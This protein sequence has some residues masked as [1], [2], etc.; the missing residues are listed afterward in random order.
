VRRRDL[1][2]RVA[3]G[4]DG[5]SPVAG[6]Y[7]HRRARGRGSRRLRAAD[8]LL[9]RQRPRP[10]QGAVRIG[11][12]RNE[13][14]DRGAERHREGGAVPGDRRSVGTRKRTDRPA[15]T[16]RHP[17]PPRAAVPPPGNAPRCA[18]SNRTLGD[19]GDGLDDYDAVLELAGD[20]GW[21]WKP[22]EAGREGVEK[23]AERS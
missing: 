12:A 15:R 5:A 3:R 21:T 13:G 7:S 11:S 1:A 22:I 8:A 9:A 16:R 17:L 10:G 14:V 18:R 20:G 6:R 2:S 19:G 23:S 4:S